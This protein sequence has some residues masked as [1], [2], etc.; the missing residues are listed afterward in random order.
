MYTAL[1]LK[2]QNVKGDSRKVGFIVRSDDTV[3]NV[4]VR[5][6]D[7]RLYTVKVNDREAGTVVKRGVGRWDIGYEVQGTLTDA[8]ERVA[9]EYQSNVE[10]AATKAV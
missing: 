9:N 1:V 8:V 6:T 3:L 4:E 10:Y 7:N 5:T 2:A